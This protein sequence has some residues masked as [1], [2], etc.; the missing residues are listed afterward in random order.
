LLMSSSHSFTAAS[1]GIST[2][3]VATYKKFNTV[4]RS[5]NVRDTHS[6]ASQLRLE[7][8]LHD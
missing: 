5:H 4:A 3:V 2:T 1:F 8:E 7:A 6:D